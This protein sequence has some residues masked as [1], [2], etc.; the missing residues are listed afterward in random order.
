MRKVLVITYYWPPSGGA[1]VQRWLKFVKYLRDFGWEPVVYTPENPEPPAIDPSLLHD[2]PDGIE[3]IKSKIWEPYSMYKKFTGQRKEEKVKAGFLSEK[4]KPKFTENISVW[5]RGNLFIPDARKYWIKPSIN[6]LLK[7]LQ[8]EKIDLIA[9]NGPPHSMHL[10]GLGLK[11]KFN[12]P[13]LADFRDPWTGIDFYD[14]LKLSKWADNKHKR[15]EMAVLNAADK[16]TTVSWSWAEDMKKICGREVEVVTNGYDHADFENAKPKS[17]KGFV[18]THIGSMNKDRNPLKFWQALRGLCDKNQ[19]FKEELKIRFI[20]F[21]DA[22]VFASLEECNLN[23]FAEKIDY[24][25]HNEV[26]DVASSS[27]ILLLSLNNTPNVQGIIPGKIFEYIAL[28]KPVVCIGPENGD[29]A[30]IIK[31]TASGWVA[32]FDDR[33]KM[34]EL[35]E[36]LYERYRKNELRIVQT[37]TGNYSRF[38][39]TRQLAGLL[40]KMIIKKG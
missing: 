37:E 21:T 25:P 5:I 11:K 4:I 1:G 15:L 2:V 8:K 28:K 36:D 9:T 18:I 7:Y 33:E 16:I 23:E 17:E 39:K 38:E 26:M 6:I 20:G 12:I 10:I 27:T 35:L 13:W 40:D 34:S 3:L 31:E 32:G 19:K 14:Q 30:K 29:S 22:A 24:L